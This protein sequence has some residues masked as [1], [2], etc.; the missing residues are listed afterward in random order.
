MADDPDTG[1]T[2]EEE[3][4]ARILGETAK[5][6][7]A[8]LQRFFAAGKAVLVAPELDL[9]DVAYQMSADNGEQVEQ[10][11]NRGLVGVVSDAQAAEWIAANALM[12]SVVVKPWILVQPVMQPDKTEGIN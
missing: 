2:L 4:L 10:W 1:L 12:W 9:V 5:I 7:W 6:P 8:D 11:M 3:A